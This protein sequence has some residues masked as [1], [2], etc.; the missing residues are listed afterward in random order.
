MACSYFLLNANRL[1]LRVG[2]SSPVGKLTSKGRIVH[3]WTND[4][5][6]MA[7]LL[8]LSMPACIAFRMLASGPDRISVTFVELL[9]T[10]RHHSMV[11]GVRSFVGIS[12]LLLS[13][14][15]FK[16]KKQERN[17]RLSPIKMQLEM[18]GNISFIFSST[19]IGATFSPPAVIIN[20]FIRP[21]RKK[22]NI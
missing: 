7:L 21:T 19:G 20:S 9:P 8:A 3:F 13:T 15:T 17:F 12:L 4:A 1:S 10:D 18:H 14:T 11:S 22:Y 16:V 6:D 2:P 5:L